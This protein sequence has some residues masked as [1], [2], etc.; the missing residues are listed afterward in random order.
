M[1]TQ[2]GVSTRS[3]TVPVGNLQNVRAVKDPDLRLQFGSVVRS[4]VT[5]RHYRVGE[6]LGSGGFGAVYRVTHVTAGTPLPGKC[7]L[8]ITLEV[9]AWL[10][11]MD[12]HALLGQNGTFQARRA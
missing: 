12:L 8:K 1:S 4:A 9:G 7:V 2:R 6:L 3:L 11:T 5:G 10:A